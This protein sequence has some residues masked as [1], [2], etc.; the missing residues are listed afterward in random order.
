MKALVLNVARMILQLTAPIAP[1]RPIP[2]RIPVRSRTGRR[3]SL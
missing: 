3:P 2:V 1:P